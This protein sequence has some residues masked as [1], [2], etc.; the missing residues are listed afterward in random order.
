[1]HRDREAPQPALVCRMSDP[2][3]AVPEHR[4]GA[5]PDSDPDPLIPGLTAVLTH[6]F[7][8]MAA[9]AQRLPVVPVPELQPLAPVR[10]DV[11]DHTGLN[12]QPELS[13]TNAQRVVHQ[14]QAPRLIPVAVIAAT[15]GAGA[16]RVM[17]ATAAS[18]LAL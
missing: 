12:N 7:A 10:L 16:L 14:V 18:H 11:I 8:I 17:A 5:G 3:L 1:M 6:G 2:V 4:S 13:T 9:L 15:M